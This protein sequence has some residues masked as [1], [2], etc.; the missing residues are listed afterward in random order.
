MAA[1]AWRKAPWEW[2]LAV[3][4]MAM[5]LLVSWRGGLPLILAGAAGSFGIALLFFPKL[6]IAKRFAA[7]P[8][9]WKIAAF[10]FAIVCD[11]SLVRILQ[12]EYI[13]ILANIKR[14]AVA[15]E[16]QTLV[17]FFATWGLG[18]AAYPM[19]ASLFLWFVSCAVPV[20]LNFW[21]GMDRQERLFLLVFW[22]VGSLV[23]TVVY[24][25][26][27]GFYLPQREGRAFF[28][29]VVFTSDTGI[30][31]SNHVFL[32]VGAIQNDINQMLF[33]VAAMPLGVLA[34]AISR[35]LFFLP[36]AFP[37]LLGSLHLGVLGV[38]LLLLTRMMNGQ[39]L[40]KILLLLLL[41]AAYPTVLFGLNLEQ[42]VISVF[43][44]IAFIYGALKQKKETRLLF[45]CATGTLMTSGVLFPLT[46]LG[47]P[48]K[49]A[50]RR[51]FLL[52]F[53][54]TALVVVFGKLPYLLTILARQGELLE[55]YGGKSL[56]L[57]EKWRQYT[58][59]IASCV[60]APATEVVLQENGLARFVMAEVTGVNALGVLLLGLSAIGFAF[61]WRDAFT[62][63]C[64][65]WL[66][67]SAFVL[68]A[69]GW[70]TVENGV[71][72]YSLYFGWAVV[73]LCYRAVYA[74]P[75][76]KMRNGV[77]ALS[78][79][80]LLAVN[81]PALLALYRFGLAYYPIG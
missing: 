31:V 70:G 48:W 13:P 69:M 22:L 57:L 27:N 29:D 3:S 45:L 63:V 8:V 37:C 12:S 76:R 71:V 33:G 36:N 2:L 68:V 49:K 7:M 50:I 10:C 14:F 23:L 46:V 60:T 55:W 41:C 17:I 74:I 19:I 61:S 53:S 24:G 66:L 40:G 58:H 56:T 5:T 47:M 1:Q 43:C 52:A 44:L 18:L 75:N 64:G 62:R 11:I 15:R 39:G 72:L 79:T 21:K 67:F 59:F 38:T 73:A 65:F 78:L 20:V 28:Y 54:F 42:Y 4:A 77:L 26:T 81:L 16:Q 51:L 30:L 80:A 35:L 6:E 9:G 25:Q 32:N 34:T